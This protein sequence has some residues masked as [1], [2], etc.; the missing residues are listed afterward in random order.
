MSAVE[1][2]Q[3]WLHIIQ[4][5]HQSLN[6]ANID[7]RY[8][9]IIK[10]FFQFVQAQNMSAVVDRIDFLL[11]HRQVQLEQL[12][13]RFANKVI[14]V[15]YDGFSS[16]AHVDSSISSSAKSL[17][18]FDRWWQKGPSVCHKAARVANIVS[19][20]M[21]LRGTTYFANFHSF[22]SN[23]LE[24]LLSAEVRNGRLTENER[25]HLTSMKAHVDSF[26]QSWF[27][28]KEWMVFFVFLTMVMVL[29]LMS[30]MFGWTEA[31]TSNDADKLDDDLERG[32]RE[33]KRRKSA[34]RVKY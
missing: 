8:K 13:N 25:S 11:K 20:E 6:D 5:L 26:R 10:H 18:D 12:V 24:L 27:K 9:E 15:N 30:Y 34:I 4:H 21:R 16:M 22:L 29:V 17:V 31:E 3:E 32:Q 2:D 14:R 28:R 33:R 7:I 19:L 1:C 23:F